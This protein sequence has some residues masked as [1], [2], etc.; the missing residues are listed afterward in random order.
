M[1]R[2]RRAGEGSGA[3]YVPYDR[4]RDLREAYRRREEPRPV[5]LVK[6]LARELRSAH[7]LGMTDVALRRGRDDAWFTARATELLTSWGVIE[8]R[9]DGDSDE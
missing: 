1:W 8:T 5:N 2:R 3:P 7:A 9:G 6:E 4:P